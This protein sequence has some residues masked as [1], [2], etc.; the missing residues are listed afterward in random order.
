MDLLRLTQGMRFYRDTFDV[1]SGVWQPVA[2]TLAVS[3]SGLQGATMADW[4]NGW[5]NV[6]FSTDTA[7]WSSEHAGIARV[8]SE[9]DPGVSS[10]PTGAADKWALRITRTSDGLQRV[11]QTPTTTIVGVTYRGGVLGYVPAAAGEL[12]H[13]FAD[14]GGGIGPTAYDEWQLITRSRTYR[15]YDDPP[16]LGMRFTG[17]IGAIGYV[18]SAFW[19]RQN[20]A[21]I[22]APWRSPNFVATLS[23]RSPAAGVVPWGWMIRRVDNLNYYEV[24]ATPNATSGN[25]LALWQVTAGVETQLLGNYVGLTSD[26]VD[27][28]RVQV[29]ADRC[30]VEVKRA[31]DANFADVFRYDGLLQG[32]SSRHHG[33]LFYET[34]QNRLEEIG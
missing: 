32:A 8:D 6:E 18:D 34:G 17:A 12:L 27:E 25:D 28:I 11:R 9:I 23:H 2:G 4:S 22:L 26:D 14:G 5:S 20:A 15:S 21:A 30:K 29:D 24:R 19:F 13:L 7:G 31:A 1:L 3:A 10:V 33:P 16:F